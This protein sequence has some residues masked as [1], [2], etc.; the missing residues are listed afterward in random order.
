MAIG[1]KVIGIINDD[2]DNNRGREGAD[3]ASNII[4]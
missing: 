4:F 1:A 2:G 3:I